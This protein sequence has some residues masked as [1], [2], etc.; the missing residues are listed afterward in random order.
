MI[1]Y[2]GTTAVSAKR[3]YDEGID[4]NANTDI[5]DFGRGFYLTTDKT[6]AIKCAYRKVYNNFLAKPC[7]VSFNIDIDRA[8]SDGAV[9]VFDTPNIAWGQFIVNN[10]NGYDYV[11][12]LK[13]QEHHN[14]DR[15]Y[16]M[17]RGMVADGSVR[18]IA[19]LVDSENR[20]LKSPE[21]PDI[22]SS[23]YPDQLSLHK[24][25]AERYILDKDKKPRLTPITGERRYR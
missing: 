11:T 14:L 4:Y 23:S 10:R 25:E 19:E 6:F 3:I 22:I 7:L 15:R 13:Q 17:V 2:H 9:L 18:R 16:I 12:R 21:L 24:K 1:F 20:L 8:I 5:G